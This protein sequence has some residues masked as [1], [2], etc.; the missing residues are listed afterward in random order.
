MI[1]DVELSRETVYKDLG[2]YFDTRLNFQ[3]HFDFIQSKAL[4]IVNFIKRNSRELKSV[5]T[6]K[7][8]LLL[9]LSVYYV[10]DTHSLIIICQLSSS[11]FAQFG[12]RK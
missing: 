5:D 6:F 10:C 8:L 11:C 4:R 7:N 9:C 1:S 12:A 2:I 3:Q